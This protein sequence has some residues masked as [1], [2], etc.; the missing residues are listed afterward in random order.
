MASVGDVVERAQPQRDGRDRVR[1]TGVHG[2]GFVATSLDGFGP[3]FVVSASEL[4]DEY[5][6][7]DVEL[8]PD[9]ATLLR[10]TDVDT[11]R[12]EVEKVWPSGRARP[13]SPLDSED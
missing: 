2:T 10:Q 13:A 12:R 8:P 9:E 6:V 1:L 4:A 11:H 3:P 7:S 5:G